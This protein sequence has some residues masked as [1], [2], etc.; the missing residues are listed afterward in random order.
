MGSPKTHILDF[1]VE[2]LCEIFICLIPDRFEEYPFDSNGYSDLFAV[3]W[4]CRAFRMISSTLPHW[5]NGNFNLGDIVLGVFRR[6]VK[7]TEFADIEGGTRRLLECLKEDKVLLETMSRKQC[8]DFRAMATLM[9]F[10]DTIPGFR[11][12]IKGLSCAE[13]AY[14][15]EQE[16]VSKI[17]KSINDALAYLGILSNLTALIIVH[18][19]SVISLNQIVALCPSL[20]RLR[21]YYN[22]WYTGSLGD[23]RHLEEF[24]FFDDELP[25]NAGSLKPLLPLNSSLSLTKLQFAINTRNNVFH[26]KSLLKFVNLHEF[27]VSPLCDQMCKT[28][29]SAN[30]AHLRKFEAVVYAETNISL[31][32]FLH[33]LQ[34]RWLSSLQMFSFTVQPLQ[35]KFNKGYL[36][37]IQTIATHLSTLEELK[38]KMG[39]NT[40]WCGLLSKLRNLKKI[41]WICVEE[42]C[43]DTNDLFANPMDASP[44]YET[45]EEIEE[46]ASLITE[47]MKVVFDGF[48]EQ[49]SVYIKILEGDDLDEY[50]EG[51]KDD[52]HRDCN[53][54]FRKAYSVYDES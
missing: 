21:F 50:W 9:Q 46:M 5:Y 11:T 23:L 35:S 38:L 16:Q 37:I 44:N 39:I 15:G 22:K 48:S 8:W 40:A 28:I 32:K 29:A 31:D 53:D 2:V 47:R 49:P 45:V 17:P 36:E 25:E 13:F 4:T 33:L 6:K 42:E 52:Y 43:V 19:R 14:W 10:S 20:K 26:S 24:I 1:P 3:R 41:V 54:P 30:Y 51:M 7:R 18:G 27:K 12:T 34:S